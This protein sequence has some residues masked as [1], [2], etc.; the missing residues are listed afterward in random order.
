MLFTPR[1]ISHGWKRVK[2]IAGQ[3][4]SVSGRALHTADRYFDIA[5]RLANSLEDV[6]P[7]SATRGVKRALDSYGQARSRIQDVR[8]KTEGTENRVK[9]N[10]PELF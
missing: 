6:A 2:H 4:W 3:A 8:D 1:N 9:G 10:V 5:A 7:T